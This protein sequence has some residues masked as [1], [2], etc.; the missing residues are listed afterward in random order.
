MLIVL[1]AINMEKVHMYT[2]MAA[3][4]VVVGV[5]C[6]VIDRNFLFHYVIVMGL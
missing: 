4:V 6:T 1:M 2:K 5:P 3:L